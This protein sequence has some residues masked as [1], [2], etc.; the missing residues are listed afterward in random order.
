M[1]PL[2]VILLYKSFF[3]ISIYGENF[4]EKFPE[5]ISG[6]N[7]RGKFPEKIS[8]EN[9]RGK[10]LG[11]ILIYREKYKRKFMVKFPI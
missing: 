2:L 11:K 10:F 8:G 6:E 7:F 5:K 3:P 1:S 9:F 4:Q